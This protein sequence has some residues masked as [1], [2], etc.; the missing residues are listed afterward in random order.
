MT[1][2]VIVFSLVHKSLSNWDIISKASKIFGFDLGY[3]W[4]FNFCKRI[5]DELTMKKNKAIISGTMQS[6][7]SAACS[8]VCCGCGK[9]GYHHSYEIMQCD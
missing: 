3:L 7:H 5:K 6:K 9:I 4:L 8:A 1:C 2:L